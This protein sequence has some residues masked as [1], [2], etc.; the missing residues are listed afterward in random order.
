MNVQHFFHRKSG[1]LTY[2][3]S[4]GSEALLIDT[5]LDY[6]EGVI[7]FDSADE[8]INT[9]RRQGL[10]LKYLLETHM[11]A[12]HLSAAKYI[13]GKLGGQ[14]AVSQKIAQVYEQWK[15]KLYHCPLAR[16]DFFVDQH[17]TLPLG[18]ETV[19]II[20]TPGHTPDSVTYKIGQYLFV[21]DTLFS[22]QRGTSRVDFPGGSAHELYESIEELYDFPDDY[23]VQLCHDYPQEQELPHIDLLIADEKQKN[24]ML[25]GSSTEQEY[26]QKRLERDA[27]LSLPKLIDVAVPFNLTHQLLA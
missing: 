2:L 11:H 15:E 8:I 10:T 26:V 22:P 7:G 14:I 12:D 4:D 16:F 9:I 21:G 19:E 17:T 24:V 5:V 1:T 25:N 23:H 20:E 27:Q 18:T 3:V 6:R 13:K